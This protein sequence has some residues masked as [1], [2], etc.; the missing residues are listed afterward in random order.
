MQSILSKEVQSMIYPIGFPVNEDGLQLYMES[1]GGRVP[2]SLRKP[3]EPYGSYGYSTDENGEIEVFIVD[4]YVP[5]EEETTA[6]YDTLKSLHTPYLGNAALEDAVRDAAEV[7]LDGLCSL[8]EAVD[9]IRDKSA[10]I[11]AE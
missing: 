7:Y 3:G 2:E 1:L 10:I 8:E 6:F 5:T 11:M 4:L 9:A